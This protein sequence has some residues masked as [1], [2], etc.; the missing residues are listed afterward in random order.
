M[1]PMEN[2]NHKLFAGSQENFSQGYFLM[3][4][5]VSN[6]HAIKIDAFSNIEKMY[7]FCPVCGKNIHQLI[8]D[9]FTQK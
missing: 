4:N 7:K 1:E 3:C 6:F 9:F 5:E 2:D 8:K